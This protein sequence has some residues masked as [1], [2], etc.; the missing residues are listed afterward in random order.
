[1]RR[2]LAVLLAVVPTLATFNG[3]ATAD[4][5]VVR[6]YEF[7]RTTTG[8]S[9]L[10]YVFDV[11]PDASGSWSDGGFAGQIAARVARSG[12]DTVLA[13]PSEVFG[14]FD[15]P[16]A[17]AGSN[18]YRVCAPAGG[19]AV[20]RTL[21][22]GGVTQYS[23]RTAAGAPNRFFV[24]LEGHSTF[25]YRAK[26]WRLARTGFS[27]RYVTG[28]GSSYLAVYAGDAGAEA[29]NRATLPGG[30]AG[31]IAAAYPPCSTSIT[32]IGAEPAPRGAGTSTLSGGHS[33]Q[34]VTCPTDV[35]HQ[36]MSDAAAH[37]TTWTLSGP[38]VGDP[39]LQHVRLFI[40]DL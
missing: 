25:R 7:V 36:F 31:S 32:A 13:L 26:G 24:A 1:V 19:C 8:S 37:R 5:R 6:M 10:S 35:F 29:F 23:D 15:D 28:E 34:Q 40:V 14:R 4:H 33:R 11:Q 21:E 16:Q 39:T 30:R 22:Y 18:D 17:G 12:T 38:V 3:V 27:Y 2:S 20:E 9:S